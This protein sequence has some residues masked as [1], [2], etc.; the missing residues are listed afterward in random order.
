MRKDEHLGDFQVVEGGQSSIGHLADNSSLTNFD[1][2][3]RISRDDPVFSMARQLR[4]KLQVDP[5]CLNNHLR[6]MMGYQQLPVILLLNPCRSHSEDFRHMFGK[7]SALSWLE[8]VFDKIGLDIEEDVSIWDIWPMIGDGWL[9]KM[10]RDGRQVELQSAILQSYEL[11]GRYLE[12]FRPPAILVLQCT[13]NWHGESKYSFLENMQNSLAQALCSSMEKALQGKC[14]AIRYS[15]HQ[16]YIIPGFHPSTIE[17]EQNEVK[18]KQLAA[19]LE[20]ILFS[21]YQPYVSRMTE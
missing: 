20:G 6:L 11:V 5:N 13:T 10:A 19:T 9:E 1:R 12:K 15:D 18:R 8:R 14:E 4:L 21:V 16:T 2:Q 3:F 7:R 17:Y